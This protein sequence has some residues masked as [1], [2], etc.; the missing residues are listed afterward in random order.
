M[1]VPIPRRLLSCILPCALFVLPLQMPGAAAAQRRG[2]TETS[3]KGSGRVHPPW[4]R[5]SGSAHAKGVIV[6]VHGVL[7]DA[8][9]TWSSGNSYWPELL[10]QD[11]TFDGQDIY[12]YGYPSPK[13]SRSFSIDEVAD[14]LRL[15]L[16]DDG[17]LRYTEI[18]FVCHSMGGLV[19]RA[20]LLKYRAVA[21]KIRLVYFFATPT[22]GSPYA[23]FRPVE[24][25]SFP[26]GRSG[27]RT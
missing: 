20:F 11:R 22:T 19:T 15:V 4:I 7:G 13:L 23:A 3:A 17:I 10:T 2:S 18:T 25:R 9:T 27:G 16:S 12:V 24:A 6:F 26:D 14:N 8:R 21:P 5:N 1:K